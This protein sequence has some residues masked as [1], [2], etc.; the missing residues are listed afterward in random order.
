VGALAM[1]RMR[2]LGSREV[3]AEWSKSL[4]YHRGMSNFCS[5]AKFLQPPRL[6]LSSS[7]ILSLTRQSL[8][9]FV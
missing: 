9:T 2:E 8:L 3:D 4:L 5:I 7:T 1:S 6:L